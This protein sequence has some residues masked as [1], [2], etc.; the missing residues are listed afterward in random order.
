MRG[1]NELRDV[2][3]GKTVYLVGKGPSLDL[4]TAID[5]KESNAVIFAIND[6]VYKVKSV[7][8]G[9]PVFAVHLTPQIT[10][11]VD[12]V[13]VIFGNATMQS[14]FFSPGSY[15]LDDGYCSKSAHPPTAKVILNALKPFE[16]KR[17]VMVCFD[18]LTSGNYKYADCIGY[19]SDVIS[20]EDRFES[21][22]QRIL[23]ALQQFDH[24]FITPEKGR[25]SDEINSRLASRAVPVC[26]HTGHSRL[27]KSND[28]DVAVVFAS[29]RH[30]LRGTCLARLQKQDPYEIVICGLPHEEERK[31]GNVHLIPEPAGCQGPSMAFDYATLEVR[32]ERILV[33]N[34][35]AEFMT[36]DWKDRI[37][38][39]PKEA[40]ICFDDFDCRGRWASFCCVPTPWYRANIFGN[41][42]KRYALDNEIAYKA[43]RDGI[44][45]YDP[46]IQVRHKRGLAT[47]EG[48][49]EDQE[50]DKAILEL[51]CPNWR[52]EIESW[53][54]K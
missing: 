53:N 47:G 26:R 51:R 33:W 7:N 40:V 19:R 20:P 46:K 3:R 52:K 45:I 44:F 48:K 41:G 37:L 10:R 27:L 8:P 11:I 22:G 28:R 43:R 6:S 1:F 54:L 39:Y 38:A 9:L 32:A 25:R 12:C 14:Y 34:D 13:S 17:V 18:A 23:N 50:Y 2:I 29:R 31:F 15:F 35:D 49:L 42:Y 16:P 30:E 24:S 4:L 5:F 36:P 21:E